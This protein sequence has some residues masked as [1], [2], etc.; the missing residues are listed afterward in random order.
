MSALIERHSR[1]LIERL[2]LLPGDDVFVA[3]RL[4]HRQ[5][6]TTVVRSLRT[7]DTAE[8][9]LDDVVDL[10]RRRPVVLVGDPGAGKSTCLKQLALKT[11][12]RD[13]FTPVYV[14]IASHTA[15][16][17]FA[18]SVA[19]QNHLSIDELHQIAS[20]H[21][22]VL[23][24]DQLNELGSAQKLGLSDV[25]AFMGRYPKT[26]LVIATRTANLPEIK[27]HVFQAIE[28]LPF[29]RPAIWQYLSEVLGEECA[30]QLDSRLDHR[31]HALCRNP[32]LLSMIV[33]V[34]DETGEIP[35]GRSRLF[36]D[37]TTSLLANWDTKAS[38]PPGAFFLDDVFVAIA[39]GLSP[40]ETSHNVLVIDRLIASATQ[41]LNRRYETA[42]TFEGVR[43][44]VYASPLLTV[45]SAEG[46]YCFV[47]QLFQEY[48]AS[49]SLLSKLVEGSLGLAELRDLASKEAWHEPLFFLC[50]SLL[51]PD[52]V[53]GDLV[54]Q[55]KL[56]LAAECLDNAPYAS[57][58][59]C[60]SIIV[61]LL[62]AYKYTDLDVAPNEAVG[63][64]IIRGLRLIFDRATSSLDLRV[65]EDVQF[66]VDKYLPATK[67]HTEIGSNEVSTEDLLYFLRANSSTLTKGDVIRTLAIRKAKEAIEIVRVYVADR[68]CP[69]RDEAIWAFGELCS[70]SETDVLLACVS[71]SESTQVI[72]ASCNALVRAALRSRDDPDHPAI[73][74]NQVVK[75]LSGFIDNVANV[76][77]ES[78]GFALMMIAEKDAG[79]VILKHMTTGADPRHR[80]MFVFLAGQLYLE[81]AAGA[82]PGLFAS[83]RSGHVREDIV[84]AA[85]QL[86]ERL[87]LRTQ[88]HGAL[89]DMLVAAL[90][91]SDS[92]VRLH[93][94]LSLRAVRDRDV[95][96][97]AD[98]ALDDRT[99]YVRHAAQGVAATARGRAVVWQPFGNWR[100]D[101]DMT[102][103][104]DT[105]VAYGARAAAIES[106]L[107]FLEREYQ[108][109]RIDIGRAMQLRTTYGQD[110]LVLLADIERT[111]RGTD[112]VELVAPIELAKQSTGRELDEEVR[113]KIERVADEKGWGAHLRE[114]IRAHKG[115]I[116][117][118]IVGVALELAKRSGLG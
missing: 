76:G 115:D 56:L 41:S 74:V 52:P 104:E 37:F 87:P 13:D 12:K 43:K 118:L 90:Q 84:R 46:R 6:L 75:H 72:A 25:M 89:A 80:G 27:A 36:E 34:F 29:S 15:G 35:H 66:F 65:R 99:M 78:A 10:S 44:R 7:N 1:R 111:L 19:E 86:L 39:G 45:G 93:A 42:E 96:R 16:T 3:P 81:E 32:L 109:G 47:H 114:K 70:D 108:S 22:V 9:F 5:R 33:A 92:V 23:I 11:A 20:E 8:C 59:F 57:P 95:G 112:L 101:I 67:S 73:D 21:S 61:Y 60:D 106:A 97:L 50:G 51:N 62:N 98:Q 68:Q 58:E 79:D 69:F 14:R 63:Y 85:G 4:K 105:L 49:R 31:M 17:S 30:A 82:L 77:R 113:L 83:E 18:N 53:L 48:Y 54:D 116:T 64:N 88:H 40:A 38:E 103:L 110:R 28:I 117:G 94:V 2:R 102:T 24:V 71:P 26:S 107:G 100:T 91:D 55:G